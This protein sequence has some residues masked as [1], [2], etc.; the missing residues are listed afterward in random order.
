M[1]VVLVHVVFDVFLAQVSISGLFFYDENAAAPVVATSCA[2]KA[3]HKAKHFAP[4]I[5][6]PLY[7]GL[8]HAC[9]FRLSRIDLLQDVPFPYKLRTLYRCISFKSGLCIVSRGR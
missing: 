5:L 9:L 3:E 6:H 7:V 1:N 8:W 2:D 4:L